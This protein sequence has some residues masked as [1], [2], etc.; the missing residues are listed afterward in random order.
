MFVYMFVYA[1]IWFDD[2]EVGWWLRLWR[3]SRWAKEWG[4]GSAISLTMEGGVVCERVGEWAA[5]MDSLWGGMR[6]R[7]TWGCGVW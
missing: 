5:L 4:V 1:H 3:C 6:L 7:L 2:S